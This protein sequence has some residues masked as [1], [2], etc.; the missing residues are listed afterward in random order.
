M[1]K[2]RPIMLAG[3]VFALASMACHDIHMD[4]DTQATE[5]RLFDDLY[6]VSVGDEV[7]AVAAGYYGTIYYT[8]DAGKTWLRGRTGTLKSIYSVSMA[9]GQHGWA[10]GQ[11]GL[12]LH[13]EDGGKTW[14]AQPN[15]KK[16]EGK[17]LFGVATVDQNTAWVVGEWG[18]RIRTRDGGK[19]WE[20]HS[21]LISED[22]PMF[23]WLTPTDQEHIRTGSAKVYDDVGLND[24]Y[25]LRA[26]AEN[27]WLIGEFG[28]IYYSDDGGNSWKESTIE[29]SAVMD[30]IV[31]GYNQLEVPEDAV[32]GLVSFATK[33]SGETH[34]K[35]AIEA[36]ASAE[37][38]Q[39]F[40]RDSGDP[41]ELFEILEARAGEVRMVLEDAGVSDDRVRLRGQPP[42]D[43]EDYLESDPQFLER[44][45]EGRISENPAVQ[46]SVMQH[47]VLFSVR[48]Q[49]ENNGMIAG[50]GGVILVTEDGGRSWYY[51]KMDLKQAVFAANAREGR[52]IAVGEKGFVRIS[53]DDG[54][55]WRPPG[56]DIFPRVF[57]Y[58]RDVNYSPSG[59]LGLIVGQ[60]G[61][62]LRSTDSGFEWRQIL[63]P[64]ADGAG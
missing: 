46:V 2:L 10:V 62:I 60:S 11:R 52:S 59:R 8:E 63:P 51:R 49:D 57:T 32:P 44:Y 22:D 23:V 55:T 43:Y 47:P 36:K 58:M 34:L 50:L 16:E 19:T 53:T 26:P 45:L 38:V 41:N 9:D 37:E 18:T 12:I 54:D 14:D 25:C 40:A 56:D 17:H 24:V 5:I 64:P 48:F 42:W 33:V 39:R 21:F 27:C 20:D 3:L 7:H 15:P 6:A 4:F 1:P 31:L 61:R 28:Y 30:P 13:T 29:G 35:V